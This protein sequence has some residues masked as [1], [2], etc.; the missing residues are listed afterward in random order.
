MQEKFIEILHALGLHKRFVG[1]KTLP[2][3]MHVLWKAAPR[4]V[5]A[6]ICFRILSALIPLA[7][8]AVSKRIIDIIVS[9]RTHTPGGS[10]WPWLIVEFLLA[11]VSLLSNRSVE[12]CDTRIGEE[13]TRQMS[14]DV[15]S[16]ASNIDLQSIEDPSFHDKLERA[17]AQ[18]TDRTSMLTALGALV[19]STVMTLSLALSVAT[20]APWLLA[21]MALCVVPGFAGETA[22]TFEGY[23]LGRR[24]TPLRRELD[25]LRMLGSSRESAKEVKMFGLGNFLV[26]RYQMLSRYVLEDTSRLARRRLFWGSLL[27]VLASIGYYGAYVFLAFE[28]LA[29]RITVGTLTFLAGAVAGA[30]VQLQSTLS[31][32]SSVS[33]QALF[34]TD[35][36]DLLAVKPRIESKP[37]AIPLP[38]PISKGIEFRDVSFRYPGGSHWVLRNLDFII[39]PGQRIALVGENGQGKTTLVKLLTRL[40]EP[41]EGTILIDGVDLR[42]YQLDDLRHEVGVI[43]Q[44]FFRY[45]MAVR[46]NVGIGREEKIHDDPALWAAAQQSGAEK[47]VSSMPWK[48]DQMLGKR[49]EGGVDLSG[50]QWQKIALSRAYIRD[51]QLL[52]LDEPTAALDAAAEAE[53]FDNFAHLTKDRMAILISHRFST[54]RMADR[55]VVLKGGRIGETGT[56]AELMA[57]GGQYARLFELQASN[58]R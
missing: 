45:D 20:Y 49:F 40:Y 41:T 54:V 37:D 22:I 33:E 43:F 53:V 17:R 35:V 12:F 51:A 14:L 32:F 21:L 38:R 13:F 42:E 48:L 58:Y 10:L 46:V 23:T 9:A 11:A 47:F 31:N 8:L 30:N 4:L 26:E 24:L 56:H 28:A 25:Y 19:Q 18:A 39:E 15:M 29:G 55:I 57:A 3:I 44:D 27:G 36:V 2:Q 1:L 5:T 7:I 52:I 6:V 16:H 50:G 34:L